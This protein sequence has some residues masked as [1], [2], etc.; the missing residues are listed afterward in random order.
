MILIGWEKMDAELRRVVASSSKK[1]RLS[2]GWE[3]DAIVMSCISG[4]VKVHAV[5][6]FT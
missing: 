2:L 4:T 5:V 6:P 1:K 3:T